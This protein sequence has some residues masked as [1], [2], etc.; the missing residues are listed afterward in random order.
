MDK[1]KTK[2]EMIKHFENMLKKEPKT[3]SK[4]RVANIMYSSFT[5]FASGF[6][7]VLTNLG[8]HPDVQ[9]LLEERTKQIFEELEEQ[10]II[11][12]KDGKYFSG[13]EKDRGGFS[14]NNQL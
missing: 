14:L 11:K 6:I 1:A 13:C 4:K 10:T 9:K 12:K 2:D 3:I 8:K 7:E 5:G